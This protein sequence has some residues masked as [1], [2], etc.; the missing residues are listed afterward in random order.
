[1]TKRPIYFD[2]NATTPVDA[3]ARDAMLPFLGDD[4]GNAASRS[5]QYGWVAE[6]A[7]EYA[8]EQ[9]AKLIGARSQEIIWTSGNASATGATYSRR[10]SSELGPL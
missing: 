4:Y 6:E 3:R 9:V 2:N 5:H 7:V 1:M 8:R 10:I